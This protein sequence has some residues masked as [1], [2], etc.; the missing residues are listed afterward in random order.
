MTTTKERRGLRFECAHICPP[1]PDFPPI[2]IV[3]Q[4]LGKRFVFSTDLLH[5]KNAADMFI[6]FEVLNGVILSRSMHPSEREV[7]IESCKGELFLTG[8]LDLRVLGIM[9]EAQAKHNSLSSS[10]DTA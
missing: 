6:A 10:V 3:R 5:N 7:F 1:N 2:F 4:V 8:V 9:R